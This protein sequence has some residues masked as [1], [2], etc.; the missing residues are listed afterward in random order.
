MLYTS[1]SEAAGGMRLSNKDWC[2]KVGYL[3]GNCNF[4]DNSVADTLVADTLVA[5]ILAVG[6]LAVGILAVGS[7][8]FV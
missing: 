5:D 3:V 4:V 2:H 1:S 6:I 7:S 8:E